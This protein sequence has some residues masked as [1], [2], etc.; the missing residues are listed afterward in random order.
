VPAHSATALTVAA[1][2][3]VGSAARHTADV[4]A[5]TALLLA[6][7]S[8][9]R[10]D[11]LKLLAGRLRMGPACGSGSRPA[12]SAIESGIAG[13][14]PPMAAWLATQRDGDHPELWIRV[15]A[16]ARLLADDVHAV[17][18][19]AVTGICLPKIHTPEQ[20]RSLGELDCA[21]KLASIRPLTNGSCSPSVSR[22]SAMTVPLTRGLVF[23]S[24][25]VARWWM[26]PS[27]VLYV[28]P[29]SGPASWPR[30][31]ASV[32]DERPIAHHR[33]RSCRHRRRRTAPPYPRPCQVIGEHCVAR[34]RWGH[35]VTPP[36]QV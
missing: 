9:R 21:P 13:S 28:E 27:S 14:W 25:R 32:Q 16:A 2:L 18:G 19:P 10:L 22:S 3:A 11:S 30:S 34:T 4:P 29:W 26:K 7:K 23:A 17:I 20:V 5:V 35:A 8:S 33:K 31:L 15:N 12:A 36:G 24:T 1:V 6:D